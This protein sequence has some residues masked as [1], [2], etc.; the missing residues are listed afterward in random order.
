MSYPDPQQQQAPPDPNAMLMGG[1]RRGRSLG[2]P[3]VKTWHKDMV[4]LAPAETVQA[5]DPE[6]GSLRYYKIKGSNPPQDDLTAP[7]WQVVLTLQTSY[8]SQDIIDDLGEDDGVRYLYI[9]GSKK[10]ESHSKW[11]AVAAA[12]RKSGAKRMDPGGRVSIGYVADGP[13]SPQATAVMSK[14]KQYQAEYVPP[15]QDWTTPAVSVSAPASAP[16]DD[17][18]PPF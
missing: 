8:S 11:V 13:K 12:V 5:R 10:P 9:D 14:P 15:S 7:V 2:F 4:I 3:S 17:E 1:N 18:E 6:D 16:F